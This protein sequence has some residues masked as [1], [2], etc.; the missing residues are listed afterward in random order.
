MS[1]ELG[2]W[3]ENTAAE[4]LEAEGYIIL[5]RNHIGR[6]G[7]I[8]IIAWDGSFVFVEV[9]HRNVGSMVEGRECVGYGKQKKL[10]RAAL[11]YLSRQADNLPARFDVIEVTGSINAGVKSIEHIK[12]AF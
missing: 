8:D 10:R 5:S 9:K 4:Y 6:Y 12:D 11:E 7:E 1:N 3:G 2:V